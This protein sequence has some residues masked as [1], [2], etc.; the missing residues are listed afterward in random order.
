MKK[1]LTVAAWAI[2]ALALPARAMEIA[3]N[4]PLVNTIV[5]T[6]QSYTIDMSAYGADTLSMSLGYSSATVMA[7]S[8]TF[9][10]GK[11]STDTITVV[12]T[13]SLVGVAGTSSLVV[14]STSSLA[15]VQ[16]TETVVIS[17]T[18]L[19]G[20]CLF[21]SWVSSGSL[22]GNKDFQVASSTAQTAL[23]LAN[24][25]TGFTA[26]AVDV[27][28][29]SSISGSTIT[30]TAHVAGSYA[31]AWAVNSSTPTAMYVSGGANFKGG[32]DNTYF[33]LNGRMYTQGTDWT[34]DT[35]YSSNTC[36]SIQN[37]INNSN[38][39]FTAS[40]ASDYVTTNIKCSS[41]GTY[42]NTY[43]LV[44]SS[45]T[46][47]A[48]SSATF[49]GG[50]NAAFIVIGT[51]TITQG[52]T[53][54]PGVWAVGSS[55]NATALN[56]SSAIANTT[57]LSSIVVSSVPGN[58]GVIYATS[59]AVGTG[60]VFYLWTSTPALTVGAAQF[61]GGV[62]TA[63]FIS[64][65]TFYIPSHGLAS[66]AEVYWSTGSGVGITPLVYGTT[67]YAIALDANDVQLALTSTGAIAGSYITLTS[68]STTGPHNFTLNPLP[69][70]GA[71][72]F[73]WQQSDDGVNWSTMTVTAANV[74]V[75]ATNVATPWSPGTSFW[76]FG[77]INTHY[78]RLWIAGPLTGQEKV[79][80]Y[81]Y[82]KRFKW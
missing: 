10:D 72:N 81:G 46:V 21:I 60:T 8:T 32:L 45:P 24:A 28:V 16:A 25:I 9:N 17:S 19:V 64:S 42:C 43:T 31:N 3:Y 2:L 77:T 70:T 23:N 1:I 54:G 11:V 35:N 55:V 68:S 48:V 74:T 69:V 67:Y 52:T 56:I 39:G 76:D 75:A 30:L 63:E 15:P 66:G 6:T 5:T 50:Q 71:I 49:L 38:F 44:S 36:V 4:Q 62:N 41:V 80:V 34:A 12:S 57:G 26:G 79:S 73:S 51:F 53:Q 47:L 82:G 14:K 61:F 20:K 78:L 37:A 33:A 7:S 18:D 29:N 22:C 65:S 27:S 13:T 58:S 40:T 59:T